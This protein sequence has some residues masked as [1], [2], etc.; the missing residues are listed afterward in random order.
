MRILTV[1]AGSSSLKL[2]L[3]RDGTSIATYDDLD[4]AAA[5]GPP[6]AVGHRVV[7][8]GHRTAPQLVDDTLLA[9]LG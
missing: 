4:A 6:D 1:N 2:S 3:V 8:G 7:H 5:D 9:Q